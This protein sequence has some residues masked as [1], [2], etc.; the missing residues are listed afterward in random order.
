LFVIEGEAQQFAGA[1]KAMKHYLAHCI[2][3]LDQMKAFVIK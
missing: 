1:L 2:A 3:G